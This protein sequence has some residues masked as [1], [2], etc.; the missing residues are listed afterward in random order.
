MATRGFTD[1]A[2]VDWLVWHVTPGQ[3]TRRS[4]G[5][6]A[7]PEELAAGWLCM[8]SLTEKRRFY[9]VPPDWETL[10]DDKLAI[11]CHAAVPVGPRIQRTASSAVGEAAGG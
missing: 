8:E 1:R 10:A 5:V 9:P 7:L 11:L 6:T 3:H 2:G 4:G